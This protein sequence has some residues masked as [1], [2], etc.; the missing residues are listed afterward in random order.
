MLPFKEIKKISDLIFFE[1]PVLSHFKDKYGKDI[2]FY[3][4]DLDEN[5]NRWLVIQVS[6]KQLY[7]YLLKNISLRNIFETPVNDIFYSVEIGDTLKYNNVIQIFKDDLNEK[8][9][10]EEGSYFESELPSHYN[11][12]KEVYEEDFLLETFLQTA[13][14]MKA[15]PKKK[16]RSK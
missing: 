11:K 7:N 3:W 4:V 10:P 1:G 15:N 12:K 14:F 8:Y 16:K 6:E 13:A 2:L 5:F 9:V